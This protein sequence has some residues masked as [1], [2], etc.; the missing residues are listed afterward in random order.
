VHGYPTADADADGGDLAIRNPSA[1]EGLAAACRDAELRADAD[2]EL[3]EGAEVEVEILA[4]V[5]QVEDGIADELAWAV[6][7]G[8]AAAIDVDDGVDEVG[9]AA[10]AG[11]IRGAAHGVNGVVLEKEEL[12]G[13]AAD[14]ALGDEAILKGEGLLEIDAAKPL[15]GKVSGRHGFR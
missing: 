9:S 11:L 6:I 7:G 12:I 3:L 13:D 14:A 5:A 2:E 15:D 8:L 1:G 4:V 10:E